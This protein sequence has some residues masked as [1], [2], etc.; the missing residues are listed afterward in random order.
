VSDPTPIPAVPE[1][2]A[3]AYAAPAADRFVHLHVHSEYSPLDGLNDPYT[4]IRIAGHAGQPA[5]AITDHG[6][7]SGTAEFWDGIAWYN[8]V[9]AERHEA[10]DACTKNG[11]HSV[12]ACEGQERC[13]KSAIEAPEGAHAVLAPIRGILGI[14]A[15][16]ADKGRLERELRDYSHLVILALNDQGWA[17]VRELASRASLEG[18][19]SYPRIDLELLSEYKE[20]IVV[21]SACLGG[22]LAKT[23]RAHGVEAADDLIGRYQAILGKENYYLELQWHNDQNLVGE[24]HDREQH[25]L[26][27]YLLGA[28]ERTGAPLVMTNDAHYSR[29]VEATDE[30]YLLAIQQRTTVAEAA[31][32]SKRGDAGAWFDTPDFYL[33]TR[34]EMGQ[35]LG[36]WMKACETHDKPTAEKIRA[37]GKAWL[38]ATLAI[39]ERATLT[40]PFRG[41]LHFP[42]FPVPDGETAESYLATRVWAKAEA[43]YPE[44]REQTRRLIAYELQCVQELGF[45]AYFLITE[46]FVDYARAEGIDVG[47]GRGSAPGSVITYVLGITDVDPIHYGLS[48]GGIGLTRFLNP[49]VLYGLTIEGFGELPTAFAPGAF[50]VPAPEVMEAEIA[51]LLREKTRAHNAAIGAKTDPATGKPYTSDAEHAAAKRLWENWKSVL[52]DEWALVKKYGL[53]NETAQVTQKETR[54][55]RGSMIEPLYRYAKAVAAGHPAGTKNE[56][57]SLVAR[58]LG[59]AT[60]EVRLLDGTAVPL[61]SHY[62]FRHSR[63]SM[64]D[65]DIDF[66]PGHD[67][68]EKVMRYVTDKYGADHVC[69]IATFGTLLAKSALTDVARSKGLPFEEAKRLTG[70]IPKKFAADSSG[71]EEA[72]PAVTLK[73]MIT[74]DRPGVVEASKELRAAMAADKLIDSIIRQAARLEG[75]KRTEGTHACG[76]LITPEPVTHYVAVSRSEKGTGKQAVHDGPTLTDKLGLL[77]V[78]FL[79]LKNLKVNRETVDRIRERTGQVVDWKTVPDD[80]PDAMKLLRDGKTLGIFQ[81]AS[82]FATGIIKGMKPRR[83]QDLMVATALGRP[84][85]ME[86]IPDY[87]NARSKGTG[88]YGDPVFEEYAKPILEETYGVLVYQEQVMLLAI[89]LADFSLPESD[90]LRK[91]TAKK[92]ATLLAKYRDKFVDGAVKK[93]VKRPFIEHYWDAVLTPFAAY[94]FNKSHS[95]AYALTAYKQA[96]LK[97]KFTPEFIAALMSVDQNEGAK[98]TGGV[99]PLAKAVAEARRLG[100]AVLP[101]DINRSTARIEI[102]KLPEGGDAL[103]M[104]LVAAKGIGE[105]PVT[106]IVAERERGGVYTSLGDFIRRTIEAE[107]EVDPETGKKLPAAVNKTVV[108][109]LAKCGAF[110]AFGD[111]KAAIARLEEYFGTTSVK[112]RAAVN[113]DAL[114]ALRRPLPQDY[115]DW[116]QELLGAYLTSHPAEGL[117]AEVWE[118]ATDTV[119]D[120]VVFGTKADDDEEGRGK[121]EVRTVVGVITKAE[122]R[123][124]RAKGI[125]FLS[126][127]IADDTGVGKWQFW[128]PRPGR[129]QPPVHEAYTRLRAG[130]EAG[131]V[132]GEGAILS[133]IFDHS[134]EYGNSLGVTDYTLVPLPRLAEEPEPAEAALARPADTTNLEPSAEQVTAGLDELFG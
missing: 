16:V 81:F 62:E 66:T 17:N 37:G 39:A 119:N 10:S 65:I 57:T 131:T 67:G 111:R 107:R 79:G 105:R 97:A 7:V 87:I 91:A 112:K 28:A 134:K 38:D 15:Y 60:P 127:T 93:G 53:A 113:F 64:P 14:E 30:G 132:K 3:S 49:T 5:I 73:E 48:E 106:A 125:E 70:L 115:L 13:P 110:D 35:A 19:Y 50:E 130:I 85:P 121:K 74:S 77:K 6:R 133:G 90:G 11:C 72:P 128:A 33:K 26:N 4:L 114:P 94:S 71:D 54:F 32:A 102:E 55:S 92:D 34:A 101:V 22:H 117:P 52:S 122:I 100:Y 88:T 46:D 21:L 12:R 44:M 9:H 123:T 31:A 116:E 109:V 68:R 45:S 86:Y 124:T 118:K 103:R 78:D 95:T 23:W 104:S 8:R 27:L 96:Y 40:E 126:G 18:F 25:E 69:Q 61:L 20:G 76:V 120:L 36:N 51:E 56:H 83:V 98:E 1:R 80:D 99:S 47:L 29:R 24:P 41:G 84:G 42:H 129:E 75:V 2:A 89:D 58:F 63:K 43:R 108:M 82:D 59:L